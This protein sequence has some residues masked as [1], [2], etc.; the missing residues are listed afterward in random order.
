VFYRHSPLESVIFQVR[1]PP[2]LRVDAE[3]PANFQEA[4]RDHYPAFQDQSIIEAPIPLPEDIARQLPPQVVS[5]FAGQIRMA[6]GSGGKRFTFASEDGSWTVSLAR[7]SLALTTQQYT[8]WETFRERLNAAIE[9]LVAEYRPSYYTRL[10][11]RY[12]NVICRSALGIDEEP[13]SHLLQPPIAAELAIDAI[14][15]SAIVAAHQ[16]H[17]PLPGSIVQLLLQHGFGENAATN[18]TCYLIDGD[19]FVQE[20]SEISDARGTAEE[21]HTQARRLFRWCITDR[22]HDALEPQPRPEDT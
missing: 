11:L 9:A 14:A 21:L 16:V 22:L 13:W 1:F 17:F 6:A 7:D 3:P 19:F 10:G 20:R 8:N 15:E 5:Q 2:L 4:I 12:R 18:E